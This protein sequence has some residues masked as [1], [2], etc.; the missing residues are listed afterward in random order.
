LNN[1]YTFSNNILVLKISN[2]TSSQFVQKIVSFSVIG[3]STYICIANVHMCIEA[4]RDKKFT[5]IVNN[6]DLVAPD[7]MPL[8]WALKLL[9]GIKQDR[10]AGMDLLPKLLE[11]AER[12]DLKVFFYGGSE[13]MLTK[14]REYVSFHFP[15]LKYH[16]YLSPPFRELTLEE[17]E[18][19][20]SIINDVA[21]NLVFVALGC[22]KQEKWMAAM[23]GKVNACMIGIG[24]ALPVMIGMQKR[25]PLWMQKFGL[26]W[27]FRLAQE[28]RRLFKRYFITNS[29]FIYYLCIE[30]FKIRILKLH[31]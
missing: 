23:K 10:V 29:L 16:N 27:F 5:E 12:K 2:G 20:A 30:F 8:V 6:A 21:A 15:N 24:G 13:A 22:P 19:H 9:Y 28:P 4:K 7:G 26:E 31:K 25:A 18:E 17:M 14:T 11:V 1:T 3:F